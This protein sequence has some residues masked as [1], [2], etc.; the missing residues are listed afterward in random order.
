M[1]GY[2][3]VRVF[4]RFFVQGATV[5]HTSDYNHGIIGCPESLWKAIMDEVNRWHVPRSNHHRY[6]P[7]LTEIQKILEGFCYSFNVVV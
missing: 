6:T 5:S 4:N 2:V 3:V 1:H 7:R